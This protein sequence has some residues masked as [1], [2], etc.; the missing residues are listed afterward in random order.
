MDTRQ[1]LAQLLVERSRIEQAIAALESLGSTGERAEAIAAGSAPAPRGGRKVS[2]AAR[3]R[4]SEAQKKRWEGKRSPAANAKTAAKSRGGRRN[5]SPEGR[6]RI[7]EA[8]R[9]MWAE[10]RKKAAKAV[11]T[12]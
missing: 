11:K 5:I 3:K 4:M 9:K 8:A 7:A 6:R 12:A 1:I 2:L 10:R